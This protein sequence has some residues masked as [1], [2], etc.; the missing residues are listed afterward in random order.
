MWQNSS[1]E[2][3]VYNASLALWGT[4]IPNGQG[5]LSNH[6]IAYPITR[7]EAQ[8]HDYIL[9][10]KGVDHPFHIHVNPFWLTRLDVPDAN[11]NLVNV[12]RRP[13]W[14][15]TTWLP[16]N[17]GRAV[18]RSRFDDYAGTFVNHCHILPHEDHG[19]MQAVEVTS[20]AAQTNYVARAQVT[21]PN[22]SPE[23]V[24]AIYP[25]MSLAEAYQRSMSMIDPTQ[26][27][28]QVYPGVDVTVTVP[29][30]PA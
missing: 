2:W 19:M 4:P 15:D 5:Y 3:V 30:P 29:V 17:M 9:V 1:E 10:T 12:M 6:A 16:R 8:A 13:R 28:G 24:T 26:N 25:R 27:T 11:G 23:E 7:A 21:A 14:Q 22:M 20:E 18:F